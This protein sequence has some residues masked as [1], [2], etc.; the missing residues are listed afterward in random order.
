MESREPQRPGYIST[1]AAAAR[2]G[3]SPEYIADL[4]RTGEIP[5]LRPRAHWLV[6]EAS[7]AARFGSPVVYRKRRRRARPT[8]ALTAAATSTP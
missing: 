8:Q 5:A 2:F 4:C 1:R 6:S 7:L 3:L